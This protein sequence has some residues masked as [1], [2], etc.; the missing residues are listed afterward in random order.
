VTQPPDRP[1]MTATRDPAAPAPARIVVWTGYA[2]FFLLGWSMLLIP[3][4]IRDVE[5]TF[6]RTDADMGLVYLLYSLAWVTGTISSGVLAGRLPRRLLMGGGPALM[7]L[8]LA[9]MAATGSWPA[10][11]AGCL[12]FALGLGLIDSGMNAVFMDLYPDRQAAALNRLHLW[13]AVGALAAPFAIGRLVAAG[14]P[15]ET[16]VAGGAVAAA[17]V[18]VVLG[19]RALPPAHRV[20]RHRMGTTLGSESDARSRRRIPVPVLVLSAAIAC[21]VATEMGVTSWLVRYL[22]D[23]PIELATL[24]LSLFWG[25]MALG[26][27]VSSFLAGRMG[28]VKLAATWSVACGVAVIASLVAPTLGLA[29]ACFA[30][31]GFAAGPVY[32][33]IMAIGGSIYPDRSSMVSSVLASAAI[34]GSI[35]YPPLMGQLSGTVGLGVSMLGA[36]LF[37]FVA[38]GLIVAGARLDPRR[39]GVTPAGASA[40]H[41]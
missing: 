3:S 25:G 22:D 20:D 16:I 11:I 24:A 15:W 41:G 13:V 23:A 10:F 30:V 19:T 37:S 40:S 4:L 18:A 26:R 21:Y 6:A 38:A 5:G 2:T 33:M 12:T 14:V 27:L 28:A 9:A 36:G 7:A 1:G 35:V 32:P 39:R 17:A 29:I 34:V 8:G 31:A